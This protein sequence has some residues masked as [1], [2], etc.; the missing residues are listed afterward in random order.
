MSE[1]S[2]FG[3]QLQILSGFPFPSANFNGE[4]EG[5]PIIR[6]RDLVKH[7]SETYFSGDYDKSYLVSQ[8]DVLVGMDGDFNAVKWC[9]QQSLLNQRICK[10]TTKDP[11]LLDQDYLYHFLQPQLNRIHESTAQTTVKH[12]SVKDL[13]GIDSKLPPLPE[14]K[15]IA[16]IL[17]GIDKTIKEL[18]TE[19]NALNNLYKSILNKLIESL[20]SEE[21]KKLYLGE[22]VNPKRKITYG[23]VQ[24]GPH[25][26][27]GVP[28]IRVSD[29]QCEFLTPDNMMRTTKELA[30][31]F[32]RSEVKT[33]DLIVALR[34]NVGLSHVIN[35]SC[36]GANLT[37]GTALISSSE[38]FV[39]N[40]LNH[41]LKSD[42]CKEQFNKFSKGS[43]FVEISLASLSLI[44]VPV[45]SIYRQQ[46]FADLLD[47]I[48]E[49]WFLKKKQLFKYK[50]LKQ[51]VSSDLLSG[52]KRVNV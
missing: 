21:V 5:L 49:T 42:Y 16:E 20:L 19:L 17:S 40:Y 45:P 7:S 29:M 23:I 12:L 32:K 39:S 44:R 25:Q 1:E 22:L 41:V 26:E 37:Q 6:I 52:R 38:K 51:G 50:N 2:I 4:G 13:Y 30:N 11:L 27:K 36:S 9:G 3:N 33:N 8:G 43:T 35:K 10:L 24:A 28:Y 15:K 48:K 14:Q 18:N 46:Y 34:G 47:S 31:K